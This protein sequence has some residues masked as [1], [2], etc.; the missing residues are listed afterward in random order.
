M[1]VNG[2]NISIS[3]ALH[4]RV[5]ALVAAFAMWAPMTA[6]RP[7]SEF[8]ESSSAL[9]PMI[10]KYEADR[11][12]LG[13]MYDDPFSEVRRARFREFY[14][15][16]QGKVEKVDFEKLDQEGRADYILFQRH[17]RERL[18]DLTTREKEQAEIAPLI[19][20]ART[21]VD[22]DE[23]RR[24]IETPKGENAARSLAE[25]VKTIAK[26]RAAAEAGL[27]ESGAGKSAATSVVAEK[28]KDRSGEV[29]LIRVSRFEASR[30]VSAMPTRRPGTSGR[31]P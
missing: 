12:S 31:S 22:L 21:I 15:E 24:R 19:P 3:K 10:T 4:R 23:A 29:K 14:G 26:A 20:F 30:A 13:Q 8:D 17:L 25:M 9:K 6:A 2:R 5:L 1:R 28:S 7:A 18:H 16:W 11:T 27:A